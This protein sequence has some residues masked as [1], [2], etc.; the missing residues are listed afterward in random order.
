MPIP[1]VIHQ[2][3]LQGAEQLPSRYRWASET[4]KRNNSGWEHRL[5]D[6]DLLIGLMRD[7]VPEWL[8][9][10]SSQEDFAARA[11]IGRYAL[12]QHFG[13][14]YADMDTVCVR[15]LGPLLRD[16]RARLFVHTSSGQ[17]WPWRFD[18]KDPFCRIGNALI[19]SVPGHP[20]WRMVSKHITAHNH[21]ATPVVFRTGPEM[22]WPIVKRYSIESPGDVHLLARR[23]MLAA[24]YLPTLYMRWYGLTRPFVHV[25]HFND[26]GRAEP[27][28]VARRL[29]QRIKL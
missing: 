14:V 12:M 29:A 3:W 26:T 23:R 15:P 25:L 19:A 16:E 24:W 13:G 1:K 5:W 17:P 18:R 6:E 8:P 22:F 21:P 9:L 20:I 2:I 10:F 4:W 27:G 28:R 11:D 7:E